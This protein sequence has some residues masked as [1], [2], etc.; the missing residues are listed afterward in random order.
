MRWLSSSWLMR[1]LVLV[2]LGLLIAGAAVFA[3]VFFHDRTALTTMPARW[4]VTWAIAAGVL[5]IWLWWDIRRNTLRHLTA[6]AWRW[7]PLG[8][9]TSIAVL[10]Y[11]SD[12]IYH[13]FITRNR[14][15]IICG[16]LALAALVLI[17]LAQQVVTAPSCTAGKGMVSHLIR[18]LPCSD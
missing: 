15:R 4:A 17:W 13:W 6:V 11:G 14:A 7:L 16:A 1:A 8:I 18:G 3:A 10:V 12:T 9:P 5:A 2:G